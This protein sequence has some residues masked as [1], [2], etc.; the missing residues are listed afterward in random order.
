MNKRG[1]KPKP[2]GEKF[3]KRMV[4]FP[5]SLLADVGEVAESNFSEFIRD[6]ATAKVKALRRRQRRE[7]ADV[8]SIPEDEGER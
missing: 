6:A 7:R 5:P 1:R 4:K 8:P 2:E 3:V